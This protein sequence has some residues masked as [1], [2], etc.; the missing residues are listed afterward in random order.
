[1][2]IELAVLAWLLPAAAMTA[3]LLAAV[4]VAVVGP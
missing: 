4:L 1:M 3:L 2:R